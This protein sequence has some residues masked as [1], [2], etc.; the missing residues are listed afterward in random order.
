MFDLKIF[1]LNHHDIKIFLV[2]INKEN[3]FLRKV[4]LSIRDK[5]PN[6]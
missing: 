2:N 3:Y 6:F 1:S 5:Y 4:K